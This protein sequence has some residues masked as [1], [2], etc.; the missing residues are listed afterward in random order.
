MEEKK[1]PPPLAFDFANEIEYDIDP[2]APRFRISGQQVGVNPTYPNTYASKKRMRLKAWEA[3]WGRYQ[4]Q[5]GDI[6]SYQ[7]DIDNSSLA[8]AL[9]RA[10]YDGENVP[11]DDYERGWP[12]GGEGGVF[13]ALLPL[14]PAAVVPDVDLTS[15]VS[16]NNALPENGRFSDL[17][18]PSALGRFTVRF[19]NEQKTAYNNW[20]NAPEAIYNADGEFLF[21][22]TGGHKDAVELMAEPDANIVGHHLVDIPNTR[23]NR[24]R[25]YHILSPA[26]RANQGGQ[27]GRCLN[28]CARFNR[29]FRHY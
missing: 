9:R 1:N 14:L 13:G 8:G 29:G 27:G 6:D 15:V 4:D 5:F 7:R 20:V 11:P 19:T 12:Q 28:R 17:N 24:K 23:A 10:K 26:G 18:L 2:A 22:G 16:K 25:L 3:G 21:G